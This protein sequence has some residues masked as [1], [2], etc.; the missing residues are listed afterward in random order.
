MSTNFWNTL[1]DVRTLSMWW[2][3]T[4][5]K[6][7]SRRSKWISVT[8]MS[9][10][11]VVSAKKATSVLFSASGAITG[12]NELNLIL[13][14][15]NRLEVRNWKKWIDSVTFWKSTTRNIYMLEG[16]GDWSCY[17][18][19]PRIYI[20][21]CPFVQIYAVTTDGLRNVVEVPIFGRIATMNVFRWKNEVCNLLG[22]FCANVIFRQLIRSLL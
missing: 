4:D 6:V 9:M 5:E 13:A 16:G 7:W 2:F 21:M 22:P 11:Y 20:F 19:R 8:Q 10:G 12:P 14:K 1:A 3:T 17:I 15:T 18:I